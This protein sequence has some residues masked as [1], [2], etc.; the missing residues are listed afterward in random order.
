MN[1]ETKLI[2]N[3]LGLLKLAEELGN[4]SQACK[5]LGYS[6]DT[7]YRYKELF[8]EGGE[9]GLQEISRRKP[10]IKN[11]I[12]LEIEKRVVA[13]ATENPAFGQVR[14]SNELKK[15]GVF[16][17]PAG[18]RCVWL[19]NDLETFKKRLKALEAKAAQEG[20]ILTEAQ[21]V[22]LEKAKEEKVAKGEIETYHPG[23]LGAQDTY[24]VGN[25]KGVGRIYQQTFIDTYAK[26]AT[27]KLY[28]R[29]VALV[30]ADMLNDRVLPMYDQYG[31]PLMRVLTD[32]GTEYCGAREHHEYQ[33]YLAIEDV[34]HTKTKAKS[35]QT[36]G[37]CERFHRTMQEEFYATA[38]RKKIY[39]TIEE[40]QV[41]VDIWLDYYNNHRPHSGKYCYGKTPM[42]TWKDS[43]HLTKEKM[44]E[45]LNQNFV[46]LP[47]SDEVEAGSA[48]EQ[49][50]RNNPI[51]WNGRG[52]EI[53][54]S[55][56]SVIPN[57]YVLE[58]PNS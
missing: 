43:I 31:I 52:G 51:G 37:I 39:S 41:D 23:Y 16:I 17:S 49:P 9:M 34:E 36:N 5:Y 30:A 25:I 26:V 38:F 35:P 54:P 48:G 58:K 32:R 53:T 46:S 57:H 47:S 33:L 56:Q 50:A 21:V 7:F 44:L 24:Y 22:A 13:F 12:E 10:I 8:E 55:Y 42:Q 14:A 19:R 29:K 15:E 20:L 28:D 27:V 40:L 11:R 18:V 4:V 45:T 2:K 1:T 6:R 3:K